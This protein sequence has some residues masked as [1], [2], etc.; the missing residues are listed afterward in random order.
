MKKLLLSAAAAV[1]LAAPLAVPAI[2]DAVAPKDYPN[3]TALNKDYPHG[4]GLV[5]AKD[6]TSGTPVTNFTRAPKV[7][8]LNTESDAD[9]DHIACEK[10]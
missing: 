8:N 6:H 9:K 2:A 1:A 10:H 4:V 3:C 5:G 7:Y